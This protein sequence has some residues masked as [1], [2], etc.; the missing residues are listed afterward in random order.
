MSRKLG[1]SSHAFT[2]VKVAVLSTDSQIRPDFSKVD[3]NWQGKIRADPLLP[4]KIWVSRRSVLKSLL[5]M[6]SRRLNNFNHRGV[7][8]AALTVVLALLTFPC[9]ACGQDDDRFEIP[10]FERLETLGELQGDGNAEGLEDIQGEA[11]PGTVAETAPRTKPRVPD[12]SEYGPVGGYPG[13]ATQADQAPTLEPQGEQILSTSRPLPNQYKSQFVEPDWFRSDSDAGSSSSVQSFLKPGQSGQSQLE[14]IQ[15]QGGQG[16]PAKL[17]TPRLQIDGMRAIEQANRAFDSSTHEIVRERYPDGSIKIVRTI[18]QDADGNYYNDGG[19]LMY[20]RAQRPIASGTY[21]RGAMEGDWER[22]HE[23]GGDGLFA[24]TPFNLFNGPYLSQANFVRNEID[25]LWTIKD[26]SGKL[27]FS[28]TFENGVRNGLAS[29]YYPTG[30]KMRETTFKKGAP[31]GFV[32]QWDQQGK[33]QRREQFVD[34]RRVIRKKSTFPNQQ[35]ASERV[36]RDR[37]LV[38]QGSDNWWAAKPATFARDGEEVQYGPVTEWYPNRQPKMTGRY[39]DGQ[40]DGLFT[41]WHKTHNKKAEG[42]FSAGERIGL[43]RYWH[44]SGMKRSEGQFE[45]DKPV[46]TWRSWDVNGQVVDEKFFSLEDSDD[47]E[48]SSDT[49]SSSES[50]LKLDSTSSVFE[51]D[52]SV[53]GDMNS[54]RDDSISNDDPFGEEV[55]AEGSGNEEPGGLN[56]LL[57]G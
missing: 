22:V 30:K 55:D 36:Y 49:E 18:A 29:W 28:I 54:E 53:S 44:E 32:L 10:D 17:T 5:E 6:V 56:S 1:V 27:I 4:C 43:W 19:W 38:P 26:K 3:S 39:V 11:I 7:V 35:L 46:G 40:R 23:S 51:D 12:F 2:L 8:C 48:L 50:E 52:S 9:E 13:G 31:H 14:Q 41:W 42:N 25:G 20:D 16:G 47:L 33:L 15:S 37:K 45:D 57:G 24:Q 21:V 34:G